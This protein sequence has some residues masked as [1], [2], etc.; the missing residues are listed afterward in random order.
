[1]PSSHHRPDQDLSFSPLRHVLHDELRQM[2]GARH[3]QVDH[4]DLFR[5][6]GLEERTADSDAC[7]DRDRVY[8]PPEAAHPF[9]EVLDATLRRQIGLNA[10]DHGAR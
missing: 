2:H 8:R 7:V 4:V 9:P 10:F 1:M 5:E 6:V 3:V